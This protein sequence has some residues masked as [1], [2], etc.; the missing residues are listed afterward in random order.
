MYIY[1]QYMLSMHSLFS[2]LSFWTSIRL[3][4]LPNHLTHLSSHHLILSSNLR[5]I[6]TY[7]SHLS[8]LVFYVAVT[9]YSSVPLP[10]YSAY[11]LCL[12]PF[13]S[14]TLNFTLVITALA[15]NIV[16]WS[17]RFTGLLLFIGRGLG[18]PGIGHLLVGYFVNYFISSI[19]GLF[20]KLLTY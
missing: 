14:F 17:A 13:H 5:P 15:D 1:Y 2:S 16:Q 20:I 12:S 11:L 6:H 3:N 19:S 10:L 7:Y 8:T 4:H 18:I 9:Q